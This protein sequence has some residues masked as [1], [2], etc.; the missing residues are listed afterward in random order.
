MHSTR[1]VSPRRARA[2]PGAREALESLLNGLMA[3]AFLAGLVVLGI[4]IAGKLKNQEISRRPGP[5]SGSSPSPGAGSRSPGAAPPEAP[6]GTDHRPGPSIDQLTTD[7]HLAVIAKEISRL[8]GEGTVLRRERAAAMAQALLQ[9]RAGPAP[10]EDRLLDPRDEFLRVD[11]TDIAGMD[12]REAADHLTRLFRKVRA[13][14]LHR[15]HVRRGA[16]E[17]VL[18]ISFPLDASLP[19]ARLELPERIRISDD[20]AQ[21]IQRKYWGLGTYYQETC[22]TP[23]ERAI[24]ERCLSRSE[25]TPEEFAFLTRKVLRE[26]VQEADTEQTRFRTRLQ[27]LESRLKSARVPDSVLTREGRRVSGRIVEEAAAHLKIDTDFGRLTIYRN[28]IREIHRSAEILQE[29]DRRLTAA[30]QHPEAYPELLAWTREWN[31]PLH[32]EY[33][34]HL[35]LMRDPADRTARM[36]AGYYQD[37]SGRWIAGGEGTS[38]LRPDAPLPTSRNE[39]R[40]RLEELGFVLRGDR[41]F[42]KTPWATGIHTLYRSSE[43][44]WTGQGVAVMTARAGESPLAVLTKTAIRPGGPQEMFLCPTGSSGT[45]SI[46]VTAPGEIVECKVRAAGSVVERD[47]LGRIEVAL[48]PEGGNLVPLYTIDAMANGEFFDVTEAVRGRRRFTVSARLTTTPD[49][50]HTYARFL[51]SLPDTTEIFWVKGS[52][53]QSAPEIDRAWAGSR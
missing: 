48:M 42:Q 30:V 45:V 16:E 27:E 37:P 28:D 17:R 24:V 25:A 2:S 53:L 38:P 22:F 9:A 43:V 31:L 51:P 7:L 50:F 12:P 26:A 32:R 8:R 14:S 29:F 23:Q 21:E 36:A 3:L 41:W 13:G 33:V 5:A 1:R 39:L 46:T 6:G 4:I 15:F 18:F 34:A 52:V 10:M 35:M 47:R 40:A 44:K 19:D 11:D 20:M 49:K